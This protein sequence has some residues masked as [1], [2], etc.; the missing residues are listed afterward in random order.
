MGENHPY[1]GLRVFELSQDET[2]LIPVDQYQLE[3]THTEVLYPLISR[4]T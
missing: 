2:T 3:Y 1:N 4:H